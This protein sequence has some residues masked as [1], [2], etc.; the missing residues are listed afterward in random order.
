MTVQLGP[1]D[2][3]A[4]A[5]VR[6]RSTMSPV[7]PAGEVLPAVVVEVDVE[8]VAGVADDGPAWDLSMPLV[9][10]PM[11]VCSTMSPLVADQVLLAV[12]V[13]VGDGDLVV[14]EPAATVQLGLPGDAVAGAGVAQHD[15]TVGLAADQVLLAVV[16]QVTDVE[17]GVRVATGDGPAGDSQATPLPPP[18]WWCAARCHRLAGGRSGPACRRC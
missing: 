2:A 5:G 4:A 18:V 9:P 10:P 6:V 14:A 7:G 3:V 8:R 12:V 16:V 13:E 17:G 1:H 15:V 11:F